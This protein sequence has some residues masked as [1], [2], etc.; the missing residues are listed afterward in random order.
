MLQAGYVALAAA[1]VLAVAP[2]A[3]ADHGKVGTWHLETKTKAADP[4]HVLIYMSGY[5]AMAFK[6]AFNKQSKSDY[7]MRPEDVKADL[8]VVP[9]C[10]VGPTTVSGPEMQANYTCT[11]ALAGSGHMIITYDKPEHYTAVS[12]YEMVSGR[13][14]VAHTTYEGTWT[15]DNCTAP[16]P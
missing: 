13:G 1:L 5:E 9:N 14:V 16:A 2:A 7:C 6:S 3:L 12:D 4:H 8:V 11:G 15:S 10:T